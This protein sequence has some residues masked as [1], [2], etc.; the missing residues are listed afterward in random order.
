MLF[1]VDTIKA[2]KNLHKKI[3]REASLSSSRKSVSRTRLAVERFQTSNVK[4]GKGSKTLAETQE[5]MRQDFL[6]Q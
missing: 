2:V 3:R 4:I 5:D 6:S 1:C